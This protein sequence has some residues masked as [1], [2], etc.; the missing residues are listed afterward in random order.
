MMATLTSVR[1][2]RIVVFICI[3]LII[4]DV[5]NFSVV[6]LA[7][8]ISSLEKCL[9]RSSAHFSIGLFAFA[10]ELCVLFVYFGN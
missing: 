10:V 8:C 6:L 7:V 5:E 9:F 3:S 1:W 4:S 2:Y